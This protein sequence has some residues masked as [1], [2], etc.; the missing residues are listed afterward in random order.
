MSITTR[1]DDKTLQFLNVCED[2][3]IG[4]PADLPNI[5]DF[6][7]DCRTMEDDALM[8]HAWNYDETFSWTLQ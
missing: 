8:Q 1:L 6:L 4:K 3:L 2:F 5:I 7:N